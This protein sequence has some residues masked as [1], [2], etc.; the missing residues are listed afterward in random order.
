MVILIFTN[1]SFWKLGLAKLQEYSWLNESSYSMLWV[2]CAI[3]NVSY[4]FCLI[5]SSDGTENNKCVEEIAVSL[6]PTKS[7]VIAKG[8]GKRASEESLVSDRKKMKLSGCRP[9]M[10]ESEGRVIFSEGM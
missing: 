9:W 8:S 6:P 4:L 10:D 1:R 3:G 2:C 7:P 5:L